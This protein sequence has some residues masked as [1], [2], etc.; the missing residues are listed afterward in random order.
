[1]HK[2]RDLSR[3]HKCHQHRAEFLQELQSLHLLCSKGLVMLIQ[4]W[5]GFLAHNL[6]V[7]RAI[8]EV[9]ICSLVLDHCSC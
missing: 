6:K 4:V 5:D 9:D 3:E 7:I 8:W 2:H 1:M